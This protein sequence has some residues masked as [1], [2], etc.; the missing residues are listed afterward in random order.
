M[1]A[2]AGASPSAGAAATAAGVSAEVTAPAFR[3]GFM[4]PKLAAVTEEPPLAEMIKALTDLGVRMNQQTADPQAP[5]SNIPAGYTYLGQLIAH[6][7]SFDN[8]KELPEKELTPKSTRSPSIDL[9]SLYGS[10]RNDPATQRIYDAASPARLAIGKTFGN[11]LK[12]LENDLPRDPT[13]GEAFIGDERNDENLVVAQMHVALIKFHNKVVDALKK[14]G[15]VDQELFA[16]AR[17]EVIRHFQWII[18]RDY[19]PKIVDPTVLAGAEDL[20]RNGKVS[21]CTS[22][23]ALFMPLEFSAAALRLGHSMVRRKYQWN[24]FHSTELGDKSGG[25]ALSQLFAQTK[26]QGSGTIGAPNPSLRSEWVIDWRRFFKFPTELGFPMVAAGAAGTDAGT[27]VA[28]KIDTNFDLHLNTITGFPDL[29]LLGEN[30][31]ITVRNLLR[32]HALGLPTGEEAVA[33]RN[34]AVPVVDGKKLRAGPY[35]DLLNNPL[36]KDKTPLWFYI[37]KEAELGDD[38]QPN[39]AGNRL[40]KLGSKIM[41]DVLLGIMKFSP[42]SILDDNDWYPK[43][44]RRGVPETDSAKFE[45]VDLLDFAGVVNSLQGM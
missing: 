16:R 44:T 36:L 12:E 33:Q 35:Q 20:V 11:G 41:V 27:N 1:A 9:D 37:L 29:G 32:G 19:L 30:R 17:E 2:R 5:D 25:A 31:S 24:L 3:F 42:I 21:W 13:S 38:T 26:F 7:I 14:E 15:V 23:E 10:D 39:S 22:K 28:K 40:G 6:E 34:G 8:S 45:M 4:I 18:L 43:Y